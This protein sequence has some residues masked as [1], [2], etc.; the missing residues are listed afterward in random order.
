M[1]EALPGWMRLWMIG[2]CKVLLETAF[3]GRN[4]CVFAVSCNG[5]KKCLIAPSRAGDPVKTTLLYISSCA[6]S[7]TTRLGGIAKYSVAVREF[8]DMKM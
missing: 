6:P 2:D 5:S 7:S 8:R 1:S 3:R 4:Q